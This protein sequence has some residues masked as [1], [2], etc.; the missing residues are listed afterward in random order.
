MVLTEINDDLWEL[1]LSRFR[2]IKT[3]KSEYDGR[4]KIKGVKLGAA[5]NGLDLMISVFIAHV[6]TNDSM[7]SFPII[8]RV[9]IRLLHGD[10][11]TQP[12]AVIADASIYTKEIREYDQE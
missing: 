11:I 9:K 2:Q 5:A 12:E 1:I 4:K 3:G 6:N 10:A 8:D 7:F